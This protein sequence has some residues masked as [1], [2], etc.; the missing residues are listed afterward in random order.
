MGGVDGDVEL[1]SGRDLDVGV[2][3]HE[4]GSD[5]G[6]LGVKGDGEGSSS[7]VGWKAW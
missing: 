1:V 2:I 5:L 4:T 6:S 3:G 7:G